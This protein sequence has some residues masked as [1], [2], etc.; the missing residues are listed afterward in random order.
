MTT[1]H[2]IN[3]A[4]TTSTASNN[5]YAFRTLGEN[6]TLT[7][8]TKD[9]KLV[10]PAIDSTSKMSGNKI[11]VFLETVTERSGA[12]VCDMFIEVSADGSNFSA[13]EGSGTNYITVSSDIDPELDTYKVYMVDLTSYNVPYFRIGINSAGVDL[14]VAYKFKLGYAYPIT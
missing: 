8:T 1:S 7:S 13:H 4:W 5:K 3:K 14:T 6:D 9:Y 12:V 2:T 11:L 10:S